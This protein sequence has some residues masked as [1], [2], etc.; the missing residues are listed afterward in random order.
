MSTSLPV[1]GYTLLDTKLHGDSELIKI[2]HANV[3]AVA[4]IRP[5]YGYYQI[6][7]AWFA[8]HSLQEIFST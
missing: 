7:L 5:C 6:R 8:A 1:F 4:E 3:Q 2:S